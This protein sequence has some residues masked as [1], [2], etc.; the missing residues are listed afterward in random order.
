M[1]EEY[2]TTGRAPAFILIAAMVGLFFQLLP[3]QAQ[4]GAKNSAKALRVMV[5]DAEKQPISAAEVTLSL[6]G[7]AIS[8]ATTD[9]NGIAAFAVEEA[10]TYSVNVNKEGL[11][12]QTQDVELSP[13]SNV[14]AL[15]VLTSR[16]QV[17]QEVNVQAQAENPV[18][19][20]AA[21]STTLERESVKRTPVKPATVA[22]ALPLVPGVVRTEDGQIEIDG[23]GENRSAFVVNSA[24]VTDPA[25]GQFGLTIPID[26]VQEIKV[27]K[28]PYLAEYGRFTAGV[29][30]VDTKP[31]GD[32]WHFE[33]NDPF[34]EFRIRSLHIRGLRDI[35]PRLNFSGPLMAHRFYNA[36]SVEYVYHQQAVRTLPFPFNESKQQSVNVFSQFDYFVSPR[37]TLTATVQVAPQSV[38]N[39]DLSFFNPQP[40]TPNFS[41]HQYTSALI[42]RLAIA[43]GLLQSTISGTKYN[44]L[45][46]PQG[47]AEMV[48][49]PTGNRGN[50]FSSQT[51]DSTRIEW[52]ESFT[53]KPIVKDGTHIFE[54]GTIISKPFDHGQFLARPFNLLGTNGNL[55]ERIDFTGGGPYQ[56]ADLEAGA[57]AQDHWLVN[58]QLSLDLGSRIERQTLSHAVRVAPRVGFSWM[59]FHNDP[60]VV[61]GGIGMFYD[62]LPLNVFS[63]ANYPQQIIT[64]YSPSGALLDG[65][66]LLPNVIGFSASTRVP[67]LDHEQVAGNFIPYSVAWNL[68]LEHPITHFL[69]IRANYLQNNSYG[70]VLLNPGIFQG[71][72]ALILSGTGGSQYRQLELTAALALNRGS[73]MFF[74]YVH[75]RARGDLNQFSGYLGN[76]PSPLIRP[77]QF[78]NL[79][80]D[81]PNRFLAWGEILLP[82][83][84]RVS[85][86]VELRNGFNYSIVDAL[87]NYVGIANSK[88]FPMFFSLDARVSKDFPLTPKYT[89]RL[90]GSGF[91]LS[92]RFNPLDVHANLADPQFG[93][94]FGN[95]K[96]R[97]RF[98]FDVLF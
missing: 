88:R 38:Q 41:S 33:L 3:L 98:D 2:K 18:E 11:Q 82:L 77:N 55:L 1:S 62:N 28:N 50:Y 19:T 6:S 8:N 25:T 30:A 59:P 90:S 61:R 37:H 93:R 87:Q 52:R 24:D 22:D 80:S 10:A 83:K 53:T 57:Y 23:A 16:I 60:T 5:Q 39:V 14:E 32:N 81:L 96:R 84:M 85:P 49:T 20:G 35:S 66:R 92:N 21:P 51:R 54:F 78:T 74:S 58:Q 7:K 40:V 34:P 97:Y 43:G 65:P 46:T 4:S 73:N 94:F 76:S 47:L 17:K 44:D 56:T 27:F 13:H 63:F 48:I 71:Q 31:G 64:T 79:S 95:Y 89:V 26:S 75:S 15:F 12:T 45:V 9:K 36:T 91:N 29:V 68:M 72:N 42:S 86:M 69:K 67:F 70:L